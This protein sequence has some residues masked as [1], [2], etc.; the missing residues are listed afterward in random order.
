MGLIFM[1]LDWA[2]FSFRSTKLTSIR[3][4]RTRV[5]TLDTKQ[6]CLVSGISAGR[7]DLDADGFEDGLREPAFDGGSDKMVC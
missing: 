6:G 2:D 3:M 7:R 4:H 5:K 1:I